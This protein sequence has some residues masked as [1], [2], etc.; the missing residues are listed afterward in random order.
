[1]PSSPRAETRDDVD[2]GK[3]NQPLKPLACA[4]ETLR[5]VQHAEGAQDACVQGGE[6]WRMLPQIFCAERAEAMFDAVRQVAQAGARLMAG[7]DAGCSARA[8]T[9]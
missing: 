1:M 9:G 3:D 5:D 2:G 6:V 7:T 8:S 4:E